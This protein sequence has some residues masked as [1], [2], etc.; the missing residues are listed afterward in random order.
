MSNGKIKIWKSKDY[1]AIAILGEKENYSVFVEKL[2]GTDALGNETWMA[3]TEVPA[4]EV[5]R[6]IKKLVEEHEAEKLELADSV[7]EK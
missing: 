1:R 6:F 7:K 2:I 5:K 3:V 4:D